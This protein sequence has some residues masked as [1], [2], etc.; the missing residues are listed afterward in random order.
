M[1]YDYPSASEN[2][3]QKTQKRPKTE[4]ILTPTISSDHI[5]QSNASDLICNIIFEVEYESSDLYVMRPE[6]LSFINNNLEQVRELWRECC[7]R[8][9]RHRS[10]KPAC[11]VTEIQRDIKPF[12]MNEHGRFPTNR[13]P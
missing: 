10:R 7:G 1:E 12:R 5:V 8:A 6:T 9:P 2:K 3:N 11:V 13:R 4:D